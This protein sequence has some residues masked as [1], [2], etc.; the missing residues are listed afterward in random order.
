MTNI[1]LFGPPGAGKGTQSERLIKKYQLVHISPGELMREEISKK[2]T[3]G[4][5]VGHYINQGKLAPNALVTNM[6]VARLAANKEGDGFL[7]DGFPR[8]VVQAKALEEKLTSYG[9]QIDAVIFLEV[10]DQELVRRIKSRA[11]IVG[12]ADDQDAAKIATRM[13]IY[14]EATLPVAQHYAQQ[15]KLFRVC[16][17]GAVDTIF[18]RIV[19]TLQ[20]VSVV[21]ALK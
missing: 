16:G 10:P 1:A 6:V 5:Q 19:A 14:R 18:A 15:N 2:T 11:Q 12:R 20:Q 3:L 13:R 4:Q 17:V 8:T 9:M 7:F 21:P